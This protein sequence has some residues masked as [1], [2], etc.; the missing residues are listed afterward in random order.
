MADNYL[1]W[2]FYGTSLGDIHSGFG[3]VHSGFGDVSPA[4][5]ASGTGAGNTFTMPGYGPGWTTFALP[6][7]E[8]LVSL[9]SSKS[10][11]IARM[12]LPV[13][14]VI[15]PPV[16]R[17]PPASLPR[18][19]SPRPIASEPFYTPEAPLTPRIEL[20]T[21]LT[22]GLTTALKRLLLPVGLLWPSEI[23]P[24]PWVY[25]PKTQPKTKPQP[26]QPKVDTL[27][28]VVSPYITYLPPEELPWIPQT[29]PLPEPSISPYIPEPMLPL[30][31]LKPISPPSRVVPDYS[32]QI[33]SPPNWPPLVSPAPSRPASTILTNPLAL[34]ASLL[35]PTVAGL[36]EPGETPKAEP[37][38]QP[39]PQ[40]IPSGA[41]T[42]EKTSKEPR[43]KCYVFLTRQKRIP[44]ND[45]QHDWRE[46]PCQ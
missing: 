41:D 12:P 3:D 36:V 32:P 44:A 4:P 18:P 21:T 9:T 35:T 16:V 37:Q 34:I 29:L 23:S 43:S 17:P 38:P 14:P 6:P 20:T 40:P 42:C 28:E 1:G 11:P 15:P 26:V 46:I 33:P 19:I 25:Q 22:Q 39:Q 27:P 45:I 8:S 5:F 31:K 13:A 10:K 2:G 30:P 7:G 24:D